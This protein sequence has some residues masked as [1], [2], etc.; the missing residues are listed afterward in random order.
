M[1][2]STWVTIILA[3]L[4]TFAMRAG[5]LAFADR[6]A[7]VPP[8]VQ[9]L[10]RQIPPAALASIVVPALL[11]PHGELDLG[12]S[13]FLA[14]IVAAAIAWKTR[15]TALTLVVGVGLVMLIDAL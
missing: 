5:F 13:R 7:D 2:S 6:M 11:R 1:I 3:G 15:N 14:G 12:T 4:A 8:T 9:R 10:L